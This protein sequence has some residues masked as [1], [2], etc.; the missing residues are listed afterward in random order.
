MSWRQQVSGSMHSASE[1]SSSEQV[2]MKVCQ[3]LETVTGSSV[4]RKSHNSRVESELKI[5][6]L[7]QM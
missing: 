4:C 1:G 7:S 3:N 5:A 6:W 2:N